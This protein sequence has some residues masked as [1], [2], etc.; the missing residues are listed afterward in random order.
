MEQINRKGSYSIKVDALEQYYGRKDLIPLWVADMDFQTPVCVKEALQKVINQGVYGYNTIPDEYFP[1]IVNWLEREQGWKVEPE[2][3]SFIPG[4]VKGIGYVLN[5]FTVAGDGVVVQPPV[6][7]PFMN[8]PKGNDRELFFNPLKETD[9]KYQMDFENL[10]QLFR[11]KKCK[12]LILCNPHNPGGIIWSRETLIRLAEIC[13]RYDVLVVSDEIHADMPLFGNRHIP[14]ASVSDA[15][16]EIS[17]TFGAPSKTFN[18][19]GI[20]S[21]YAV[22]PNPRLREK[23]YKWMQVNEL[24]S[25]TIFAT[26]G[27]TAAYTQGRAWREEM[28]RYLEENVIFVEDYLSG[29]YETMLIKPLRPQSS[30]LIWLDCRPL[31]EKLFGRADEAEQKLLTDL[32]INKA[33]LALNDGAAF[34]PGGAGHMRLNIGCG[35]EVL[36]EALTK[37]KTAI[38]R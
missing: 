33:G 28:L 4:I 13:R 18:M 16:A 2:W 3:L 23:F 21:S 1:S 15:A 17:I 31:C 38:E 30:F 7:P 34:G 27:A 9:G 32:F 8:V 6:Y 22:V 25:P 37:L 12:V 19:A 5:F 10:E 35:K 26:V 36:K 29:N 20:V 24:N 14:F 11:T